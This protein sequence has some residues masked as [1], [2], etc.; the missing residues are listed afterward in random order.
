[1]WGA[2]NP[3]EI[4]GTW[5][6]FRG[7]VVYGAP[8]SYCFIVEYDCLSSTIFGRGL[9]FDGVDDYVYVPPFANDNSALTVEARIRLEEIPTVSDFNIVSHLTGYSGYD[10]RVR[11]PGLLPHGTVEFSLPG[12]GLASNTVLQA[13]GC[14]HLAGTFDGTTM[15]LYIDGM[16]DAERTASATGTSW[17]QLNIGRNFYISSEH[18]KGDIDEVRLS[19]AAKAPSEFCLT[20]ECTPDGSTALWHFDE[21]SGDIALDAANAHDG[22]IYGASRVDNCA[23]CTCPCHGDP[24]CDSVANLQDV[25]QTVNVAFRGATPETDPL[26]PRERTD[27]S[28]DGVTTV[29]DVVKAVNVAFRGANTATEFCNPCAP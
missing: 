23:C 13:G 15:R 2:T 8:Y 1:M 22:T 5:N 26:C 20:G 27:V 7:D 14:Y 18:F 24:Q 12:A 6:D 9:R 4:P 10:L 11:G 29:V 19:R 25:V 17:F 16:L 3:P 28:C 21:A